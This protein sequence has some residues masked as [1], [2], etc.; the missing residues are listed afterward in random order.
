MDDRAK[1]MSEIMSLL[2]YVSSL[3]SFF[4]QY[5]SLYA[6]AF[7]VIIAGITCGINWHYQ[8]RRLELIKN[9]QD[10]DDSF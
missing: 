10:D 2:T 3:C 6:P 8:R 7:G 1:L 5:L 4:L 9:K